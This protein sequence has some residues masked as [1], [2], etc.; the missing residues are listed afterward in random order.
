MLVST[1]AEVVTSSRF[2]QLVGYYKALKKRHGRC[3]IYF[4]SSLSALK[5][6]AYSVALEAPVFLSPKQV[7]VSNFLIFG[8]CVKLLTFQTVGKISFPWSYTPVNQQIAIEK[9]SIF[10]AILPG[11][12][13]DFPWLFSMAGYVSLPEGNLPPHGFRE[14]H[15]LDRNSSRNGAWDKQAMGVWASG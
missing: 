11:K 7:E 12:M 15:G 9:S 10:D 1:T 2:C 5:T 8:G 13:V 6:S 14:P 4:I 3:A